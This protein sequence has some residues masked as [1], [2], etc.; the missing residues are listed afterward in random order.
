MFG[1]IVG[2]SLCEGPTT[3]WSKVSG[4]VFLMVFKRHILYVVK[5]TD[6]VTVGLLQ[7]IDLLLFLTITSA[8]FIII[9]SDY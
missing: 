1:Y 5:S 6:I 9:Q 4:I 7:L 8:I 2:S 3:T